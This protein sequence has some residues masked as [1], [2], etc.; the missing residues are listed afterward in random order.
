MARYQATDEYMPSVLNENIIILAKLGAE[1]LVTGQ[2]ASNDLVADM[3]EDEDFD[4][5]MVQDEE[6]DWE[7]KY[8]H[9]SWTLS[10]QCDYKRFWIVVRPPKGETSSVLFSIKNDDVVLIRHPIDEHMTPLST[11]I[12]EICKQEV[13]K[14]RRFRRVMCQNPNTNEYVLRLQMGV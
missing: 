2:M 8:T 9:E 11:S 4:W 10:C 14:Q 6:E 7:A 12:M 1:Q 13:A 5:T 3:A